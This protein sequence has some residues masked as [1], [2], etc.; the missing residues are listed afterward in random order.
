MSGRHIRPALDVPRVQRERTKALH[1]APSLQVTHHLSSRETHLLEMASL[2]VAAEHYA[3]SGY[4]VTPENAIAGAFRV[5]TSSR[6]YRKSFSWFRAESPTCAVEIHGNLA[7][8][9]AYGVDT[10]I[11]VLDVGVVKADS[12]TFRGPGK[13]DE[14]IRNSDLVTFLEAKHLV[15]YP[16][17][18]AQFIGIVHEVAP[19]FISGS[20]RPRN[21][22][23]DRHFD[24][25]LVTVGSLARTSSAIRDG[26]RDRSIHVG[27]LTNFDVKI[28][29]LRAHGSSMS[30]LEGD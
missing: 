8:Q 22:V 2:A 12:P 19:G 29:W 1:W 20:R 25:A 6:G 5:K 9:S 28:A 30:P 15:A 26:F 4:T 17:L 18:L 27:I 7:V 3:R 16:M 11:Y 14:W 24:P 23:K 13:T 21:F 10:G